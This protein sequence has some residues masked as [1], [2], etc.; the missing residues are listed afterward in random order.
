MFSMTLFII[1]CALL[2][3]FLIA[4]IMTLMKRTEV[5]ISFLKTPGEVVAFEEIRDSD[6][7][8]SR[9][10]PIIK[11]SVDGK[12]YTGKPTILLP[13]SNDDITNRSRAVTI[14][15]NP[16]DPLDF[17]CEEDRSMRAGCIFL[18]VT[19]AAGIITWI[20]KA[21]W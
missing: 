4:S 10:M 3:I 15:Y 2:G 16:K 19:I 21:G 9:Y 20:M 14:L 12:E 6:G 11:F 8:P 18:F 7:G 1:W 17:T 5:N 13:W